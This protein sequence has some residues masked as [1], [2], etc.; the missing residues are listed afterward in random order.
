MSAKVGLNFQLSASVSRFE[1]A[2]YRVE[3]RLGELDKSGRKAAAGIATLKNLAIGAAAIKG[4]TTLTG[5]LRGASSAVT[6]FFGN[7]A[8]EADA[9]AKLASAIGISS[10]SL[11]TFQV[12]ASRAGIGPEELSAALR[13]VTQRVG[14][15]KLGIGEASKTFQLLGL[16]LETLGKQAPDRQFVTIARAIAAVPD[17]AGRAALAVKLFEETGVKFLPLLNTLGTQFSVVKDEIDSLGIGLSSVQFSNIEKLNDTMDTLKR[18]L[19]VIGG[20]GIG[21]QVL[22][23]IA[24]FFTDL[25]EQVLEAVKKFEFAGQVGGTAVANYITEAFFKGALLIG[26]FADTLYAKLI[27]AFTFLASLVEKLAG[28]FKYIAPESVSEEGKQLEKKRD[29]A[30]LRASQAQRML[31]TPDFGGR[32]RSLEEKREILEVKKQAEQQAKDFDKQRKEA[33]ARFIRKR[34]G[35]ADPGEEMGAFAAAQRTALGFV[36]SRIKAAKTPEEVAGALGIADRLGVDRDAAGNMVAD[37]E[38]RRARLRQI[39]TDR[40]QELKIARDQQERAAAEAGQDDIR[41]RTGQAIAAMRQRQEAANMLPGIAAREQLMAESPFQLGKPLFMQGAA[42]AAV[43]AQLDQAMERFDPQMQPLFKRQDEL[44][45]RR[46][47]AQARVDAFR[48]Q[49]EAGQLTPLLARGS[50]MADAAVASGQMTREQA[51]AKLERDSQTLRDRFEQLLKP[52]VDQFRENAFRG[53]ERL[54]EKLKADFDAARQ[55]PQPR[56]ADGALPGQAAAKD[57]QVAKNTSE[58][59]RLLQ[60][61]FRSLERQMGVVEV[62]IA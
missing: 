26:A 14:E 29:A 46:A 52:Q 48:R 55:R 4:I 38:E 34:Y 56:Q 16:N 25:I 39:A 31:D 59:N 57:D 53:L 21:G 27:Q 30:R 58:T 44:A 9:T 18:T 37:A 43:Q 54:Q 2:M 17:A 36:E 50:L 32:P 3:R 19:G 13:K 28:I 7:I 24:P 40:Q 5:A 8:Q 12:I 61:G 62:R 35:I 10:S 15:A 1:K 49:Q 45:E 60:S 33:D 41:K 42:G 20:G 6:T 23:N 11:Q 51:D 22:G 47:K